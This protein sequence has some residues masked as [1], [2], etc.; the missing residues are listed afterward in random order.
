MRSRRKQNLDIDVYA[1][2][3]LD[4]V[5]FTGK[6]RTH[7]KRK[8][9]RSFVSRFFS[10]IGSIA[11]FAAQGLMS[12]ANS[13]KRFSILDSDEGRHERTKRTKIPKSGFKA[14]ETL[15]PANRLRQEFA[16][17]LKRSSKERLSLR[18]FSTPIAAALVFCIAVT[19]IFTMVMPD[20]HVRVTVNDNGYKVAA[21]TNSSNIGEFI[22]DSSLDLE[23]GDFV[24]LPNDMKLYEGM[25]IPISRNAPIKIVS[26]GQTFEVYLLAGTVQ[27]ALA[28][29]GIK[30]SP[31]DSV[32]PSLNTSLT[33]GMEIVHSALI[34]DVITAEEPIKHSQVTKKTDALLEGQS[35]L[36][37]A[38]SDGIKKV[39][40]RVTYKDGVEVSRESVDEIVI[41][42]PIT[43][44]VLIGISQVIQPEATP[45]AEDTPAVEDTPEP[46]ATGG[47]T[48]LTAQAE[49]KETLKPTEKPKKTNAPTK[50]PEN[51]ATERPTKKPT[52]EPTL[53]PTKAPTP[54]PTK[55]PTPK[56]KPT[57]TQKA[58]EKPDDDSKDSD[59]PKALEGRDVKKT[60]EIMITA[61]TH[62]GR[63]TATGTWPKVG[64]IA[65]DPK[66]IP[67]GT[68]IYVPGYGFGVAEDTGAFRGKR[69][70]I[71]LFMD[72]EKECRSWGRK[73]NVTIYLLK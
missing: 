7:K 42:K 44:E 66:V 68:K 20:R 11:L 31:E 12:L 21:L 28:E 35:E 50:R 26:A 39:T 32:T 46:T 4:G 29:A 58:T 23:K 24:P 72:S 1:N 13:V 5:L 37:K 45:E 38:G 62:T 55:E 65:V 54:K 34:S 56:P 8:T 67:Y 14:P 33:A 3:H 70:Q 6:S 9:V 60:L 40:Y 73:R 41:K 16:R 49:K 22:T 59:L 43:A 25:E 19:V 27:D 15:D 17:G 2:L 18:S 51:K 36:K 53:K 47:K 64:T 52:A 30:I 48:G 10:G 61:Y 63:K 69:N 57:P 71:D